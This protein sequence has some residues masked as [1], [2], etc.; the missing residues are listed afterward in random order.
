MEHKFSVIIPVYNGEN[1]I[2]RAINSIIT[3]T[4]GNWELV[5]INDGSTDDTQ[6][7]VSSYM[8]QDKRIRMFVMPNNHGRFS[9]RNLGMKLAAGN[10]FCHLDVDDEFMSTYFE[11][12]ND[13]INRN[14][15]YDIFHFGMLVKDREI[16][17]NQRYEKGYRII[18]PFKL[19]EA[20]EGMKT[21]DKGHIGIG[22]F[23]FRKELI[24]EIGYYPETKIP[25]GGDDSLPA[26]LVRQNPIYKEICK[27]N[28]E[29]QWLPLGNPN[30]DDYAL[31]WGLTRKHKSKMIDVL[32]YIQHIR[33]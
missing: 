33:I 9:A 5:V 14:P 6:R 18:E 30:G 20:K 23:V 31:F 15:D 12:V 22:S 25:Y 1:T 19:E 8:K 27:Q 24:N 28:K 26:L 17:N 11:V 4:Y 13:E 3:Q 10:W 21:F 7:V 2:G 32:L 29:G 16:V